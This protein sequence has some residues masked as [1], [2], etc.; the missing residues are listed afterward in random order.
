ML[1][2]GAVE[3]NTPAQGALRRFTQWPRIEH[4]AFQLRGAHFTTELLPSNFSKI[5]FM[6]HSTKKTVI[7]AKEQNLNKKW[8]NLHATYFSNTFNTAWESCT[9]TAA[10]GK[11]LYFT[12]QQRL[13]LALPCACSIRFSILAFCTLLVS[14]T[15]GTP[16]S[17][18]LGRG[19]PAVVVVNA[20]LVASLW[21]HPLPST[22]L[23]WPQ[24]SC[25]KSSARPTGESNPVYQV[26]WCVF[27]PP[28]TFIN[29]LEL[30]S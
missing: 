23:N 9:Q 28:F 3:V 22:R 5:S 6:E 16:I 4:P 19:P 30:F 24:V 20:A 11:G 12:W 25:Y 21:P 29:F 7:S 1:F 10:E 27:S 14:V 15:S 13:R 2:V 18:C 8:L 26:Q 17:A